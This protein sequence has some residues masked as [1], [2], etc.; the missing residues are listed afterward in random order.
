M[1]EGHS[2]YHILHKGDDKYTLIGN[3]APT[4]RTACC[5]HVRELQG[6]EKSAKIRS[7]PH[8]RFQKRRYEACAREVACVVM[9]VFGVTVAGR[10]DGSVRI[11]RVF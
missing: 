1:Q 3:F 9:S 10:A 11:L 4:S 5:Q 6:R 8:T 2:R 7:G